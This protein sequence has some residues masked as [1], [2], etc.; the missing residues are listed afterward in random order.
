[1]KTKLIRVHPKFKQML[2]ET[3]NRLNVELE[4][5]LTM[6]EL[7]EIIAVGNNNGKQKVMV[8]NIPIILLPVL[9]SRGRPKKNGW[10]GK[11]VNIVLEDE[12]R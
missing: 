3:L 6:I 11:F 5:K 1:M 12:P 7:T 4:K 8:C 2:K 10:R 9:R